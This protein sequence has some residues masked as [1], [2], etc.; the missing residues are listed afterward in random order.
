MYTFM[1]GMVME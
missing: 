1:E